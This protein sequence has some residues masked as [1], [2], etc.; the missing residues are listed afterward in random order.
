MSTVLRPELSVMRGKMYHGVPTGSRAPV[1]G[2]GA[3]K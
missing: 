3:R 2:S 1:A